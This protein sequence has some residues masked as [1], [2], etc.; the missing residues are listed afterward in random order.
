MQEALILVGCRVLDPAS[1][2]DGLGDVVVVDGRIAERVP[3]GARETRVEASGLWVLPGLLDLHV[4][5]R[6]PGGEAS[7]T[8]ATGAAAAAR[9][10]FTRV[11]TMPNTKP[12][13]DTPA[14]VRHQ[15]EASAALPVDILPSACCTTGRRGAEVAE[16]AALRAAGASAFTDDGSMV[17]DDAVMER[18]M[19]RAAALGVVV[20]EHAVVPETAAGG[21]VRDGALARAHGLPVFRDA[22][23]TEAVARDIRLAR[24]TGCRMHIQHLSCAASVELIRAARR[25][26]LPVT[27]EVTPHHLLLAAEDIPGDDANWKMNPPLGTRDDVAA[28]RAAVLEG[29]VQCCATDHAPHASEL[30]DGGFRNTMF[31][32]LGLETAVG[33]SL[34]ALVV[35]G[36]LTPLAWAASWTTGPAAILGVDAPSLAPGSR[37]DVCVVR[38]GTWVFGAEDIVSKSRN[39]PFVGMRLEGR[40]VATIRAGRFTWRNPGL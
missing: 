18:V 2:R 15:I 12:P 17:V 36:G 1:G 3:P 27:A 35:E 29:V 22:A 23:E 20:M 28:L 38:P 5:F 25:E 21:V 32:V 9:G 31:G 26:G 11:V 19:R 30:K 16:L 24:L 8:L 39:S 13:I 4:H 10:G 33:A 37:A 34:R 40:A 7:E 6:E 14:L